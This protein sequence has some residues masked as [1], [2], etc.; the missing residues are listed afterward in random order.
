MDLAARQDSA[1]KACA[2]LHALDGLNRH[3]RAGELAIE[4]AVP[5]DM[6]AKSCRQAAHR[7]LK[8][9]AERIARLARLLD[10]RLHLRLCLGVVAVELRADILAKFCAVDLRR[11]NGH[12]A[13]VHDL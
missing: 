2:D 13:D 11:V 10:L 8:D 12:P 5:L 1:V 3:Q 7:D 4:A 6:T 9:A